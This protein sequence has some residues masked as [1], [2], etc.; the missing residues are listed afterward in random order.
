MKPAVTLR[1]KIAG[2]DPVLGIMATFHFWPGLVE[3]AMKAGLDYLIIDLEH[4]THDQEAVAEACTLG[5]L[6]GFPI[7]IRPPQPE[8]SRVHLAMDLG[9][10]GLLVPY[11][12]S[13]ADMD[14]V[15]DAVYMKPRGRRRP[16]GP[17]NAWIMDHDYD[18][19]TWRREVEDQL[20]ILPQIESRRG[21]DNVEAIAQHPLTTAMAIGPYD[22]SADLGICWE[23]EH[24]ELVQA[25][26]RIKQAAADAGKNMWAIG[27]GAVMRQRGFNFICL[28]E[29][30]M[31]LQTSLGEL[32]A[33]H[34]QEAAVGSG[35]EEKDEIPI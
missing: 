29:A 20:I 9:P 35:P 32:A 27:D 11:V 34:R 8:F 18:Y 19:S 30:T 10:C 26:A 28:T 1:Q 22:L 7:L 23:P 5:R 13:T 14:M 31:H 6:A 16:G 3:V 33:E 4:L 17:G 24:P 2:P 21:L 12:E 25:F 15:R